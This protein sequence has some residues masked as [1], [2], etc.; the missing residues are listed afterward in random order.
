MY[1]AAEH[2]C[3]DVIDI[4][5]NQRNID[6]QRPFFMSC[7]K[8]TKVI[9]PFSL[10]KI[11]SYSFY[12]CSSLKDVSLPNSLMSIGDF[13]F[14][15]CESLTEILIP[16]SV[17]EMGKNSFSCCSSLWQ[18]SIP[19]NVIYIEDYTFFKCSSLKEV[20]LS[21][22]IIIGECSFYE[23]MALTEIKIPSTV[24][25]IGDR[26]FY[27]CKS[28]TSI[29]IP[30]SLIL[31][32]KDAVSNC[33]CLNH[34]NLQQ[35]EELTPYEMELRSLS[36]QQEIQF[37]TP[38]KLIDEFLKLNGAEIDS[39]SLVVQ[40]HDIS[41]RY[42]CPFIS[43][44]SGKTRKTQVFV[45]QHYKT[46]FQCRACVKY[47][48]DSVKNLFLIDEIQRTHTHHIDQVSQRKGR[49]T[50]TDDQKNI[51]INLT[52]KGLTAGRIRLHENLDC[53]PYVLYG[54]R[55]KIIKEMRSNEMQQMKDEIMNWNNWSHLIYKDKKDRFCCL[56][57]FF[58]PVINSYYSSSICVIDD[59]S[60]TNY[61]GQSLFVI[62][63]IDEN[64]HDQVLSFALMSKKTI[65]SISRFFRELKKKVGNIRIFLT[66][67]NKAQIESLKLIWPESQIIYCAVHIGR[68]IKNVVG[69]EMFKFYIQMRKEIISEDD[70][71]D[72]FREYIRKHNDDPNYS[73][74]NNLLKTLLKEIDHWLPSKIDIYEHCD[75]DTTNRI[76]G[77]FG[78]LK[79]LT[80]HHILSF[81]YLLKA[82]FI[83]AKRFKASSANQKQSSINPYIISIQEQNQISSF[84]L[85]KVLC[86]FNEIEFEDD[87]Y[88]H[89]HSCCITRIV[90]GIPCKHILKQRKSE[91]KD[92][93]LTINDFSQRWLHSI[94]Y[95]I[96]INVKSSISSQI[97][98]EDDSFDFSYASLIGEFEK[99]FSAASKCK[100]IQAALVDCLNTLDQ[101]EVNPEGNSDLLP[102]SHLKI[103]GAPKT[104]P[105]LM[106]DHNESKNKKKTKKNPEKSYKTDSKILVESEDEY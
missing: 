10:E 60:C 103:P 78:N 39:H 50:L 87:N 7:Q 15:K 94:D 2:N 59:T 28:L 25:E 56:Y 102:P 38:K 101:I 73:K 70:L 84:A 68:N 91:N 51:I 4:L 27:G 74:A 3:I 77:F 66:D 37:Q 36:E 9:L 26:A 95:N 89:S 44:Y 83:L 16:P 96:D 71:L 18:I 22:C 67:R 69:D 82:I 17:T 61:F 12:G 64:Y 93:L 42:G 8:L 41:I 97:L 1:L 43:L 24:T 55:R 104:R 106:V 46:S 35:I 30:P 76:E 88:L 48:Y 34:S 53:S 13:A 58:E 49:N 99:Y 29:S 45:C 63:A 79:T 23:C 32:G 92:P 62:M 57:G 5:I 75:T 11:P 6:L 40:I 52:K 54:V 31:V 81:K 90:Y 20:S 98:E 14:S 65:K 100:P 47:Y 85:D 33:P 72:K 21:S 19:S 80:D 86:E 105:R